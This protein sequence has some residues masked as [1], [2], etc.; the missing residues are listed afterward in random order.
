MS[1]RT[2]IVLVVMVIAV[3]AATWAMLGPAIAQT[4]PATQKPPQDK[5]ALAELEVKQL[6][7][8]M[9]TDKNGKISKQ[10]WM[11]FMEA[12][13]NRLDTDHS[14]G[15]GRQGIDAITIA[16][17]ARQRGKVTGAHNQMVL[18]PVNDS[19]YQRNRSQTGLVGTGLESAA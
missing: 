17:E 2:N 14:G 4:K 19:L 8:L 9:D 1:T 11:A 15:I 13:F 7:L 16:A 18:R 3:L 12:E 6:L 10:E 5:L